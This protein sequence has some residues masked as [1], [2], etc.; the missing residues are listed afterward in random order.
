MR[1]GGGRVS[2]AMA[3][4]VLLSLTIQE[5]GRDGTFR[6]N[7]STGGIVGHA[8]ICTLDAAGLD[9]SAESDQTQGHT[10][11]RCAVDVRHATRKQTYRRLQTAAQ[12]S[13]DCRALGV[14]QDT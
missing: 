4:T 1:P 6:R 9:N 11:V 2:K 14:W 10:V 13:P 7:S 12:S 5:Y 3:L 8:Y